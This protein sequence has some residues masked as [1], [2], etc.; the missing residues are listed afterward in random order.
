V[1]HPHEYFERLAVLE[2]S[3]V[4]TNPESQ[5]LQEHMRTCAA[6]RETAD[7]CATVGLLMGIAAEHSHPTRVPPNLV[8]RL[9]CI[10]SAENEPAGVRSRSSLLPIISATTM[11]FVL[12]AASFV[13]G[14]RTRGPGAAS[15]SSPAQAI[16]QPRS[17]VTLPNQNN[18][19]LH[20]ITVQLRTRTEELR[21]ARENLSELKQK[22]QLLQDR[23]A[24]L[25]DSRQRTQLDAEDRQQQIEKLKA[26][27]KTLTS[28][29]QADHLA[30]SV[31][32]GEVRRLQ[33]SEAKLKSEL[34]ESKRVQALLADA[35]QLIVDRNMHTFYVSD[36]K[37]GKQGH[38]FGR[39]FYSEGKLFK[40]YAW[41]LN[42][43][44]KAKES[45]FYLWGETQDGRQQV[46]SLGQFQIDNAADGRWLLRAD[47]RLLSQVNAVFVTRE[48]GLTV[49]QPTGE[50]MLSREIKPV[51]Q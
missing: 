45:R 35:Q 7:Q 51:H 40:F 17:S 48:K 33:E 14:R 11:V 18:A 13:I 15:P 39:I 38:A 10:D 9:K 2:S 46:V 6:C 30:A 23:I 4:L 31:S 24:S 1:A 37:P 20:D 34:D 25:Q 28:Q 8:R 42:D 29:E 27:L 47:P 5:E 36:D 12:M 32:E 49:K 22:S 43:P 16:E 3:G 21:I 50:R 41:D 26:E 19:Q 44:A